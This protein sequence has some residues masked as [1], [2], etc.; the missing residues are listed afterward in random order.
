[1][2]QRLQF[3]GTLAKSILSPA[4]ARK[5]TFL[6]CIDACVTQ[7]VKFL[8]S[9]V[10]L[11]KRCG[12]LIYFSCSAP[13]LHLHYEDTCLFSKKTHSC[14]LFSDFLPLHFFCLLF[15][16]PLCTTFEPKNPFYLFLL[17]AVLFLIYC[18]FILFMQQYLM[19]STKRKSFL[20]TLLF[21]FFFPLGTMNLLVDFIDCFTDCEAY[22]GVLSCL[23]ES[24]LPVRILLS[25][26][27]QL[28]NV[29]QFCKNFCLS[30][31]S[32]QSRFGHTSGAQKS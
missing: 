25:F 28:Y 9:H 32:S 19:I 18:H 4:L 16:Q 26:F 23:S 2:D 7:V 27:L 17:R 12:L 14:Y 8:I 29:E 30:F 13:D 10:S 5:L 24:F 31:Q 3:Q 6:S 21:S 22:S 15:L 1:M 20:S 11:R